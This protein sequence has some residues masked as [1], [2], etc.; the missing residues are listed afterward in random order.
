MT[1]FWTLAGLVL[2]GL[3]SLTPAFASGTPADQ[4]ARPVIVLGEDGSLLRWTPGSAVLSPL[5][6]PWIPVNDLAAAGARDRVLILTDAAA[7]EAGK[8]SKGEGRAILLD[9]AP[10]TPAAIRTI[11]FPGRG[12]KATVSADGRKAYILAYATGKDSSRAPQ[13]GGRALLHALDLTTGKVIAS[14]SLDQIPNA[15]ALDAPGRRLF[16]SLKGRILSY[17]TAPLASSWHYRSPGINRGLAVRPG[18]DVLFVERERQVAV[19][20]PKEIDARDAVKRR[21]RDDDATTIIAL[22]IE[23]AALAF[24]DDGR[25]ILAFGRGDRFAFVDGEA[26]WGVIAPDTPADLKGSEV[27]RPVFF[28]SGTADLLLAS[29]PGRKVVPV[30]SPPE[31]LSSS[32]D[33]VQEQGEPVEPETPVAPD[34]QP[35]P[36]EQP[37]PAGPPALSPSPTPSPSPAPDTAA[38]RA[39]GGPVAMEAKALRGKVTGDRRRVQAIVIYGPDSIVHEHGRT[40]PG[41]DGAWEAPLPP[42]GTYRLVPLGERSSALRSVPSFLTV[43]VEGEGWADLDFRVPESGPTR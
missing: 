7:E 23:A 35:P 30:P 8:R 20:D 31:F 42:P 26:K 41:P 17:T 36:A 13:P 24:S 4:A 33:E 11:S 6:V 19:F 2:G 3:A 15:I 32:S 27:V 28:P 38:P 40:Q 43:K 5:V 22:P 39:G 34:D 10:A 1:R 29:L 25:M 18:S 16:L 9:T 37:P 21:S 12:I 14:A